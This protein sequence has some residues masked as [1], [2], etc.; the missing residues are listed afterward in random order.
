[1]PN[2]TSQ[3]DSQKQTILCYTDSCRHLE[4]SV[5]PCHLSQAVFQT[6]I[7]IKDKSKQCHNNN[8]NNKRNKTLAICNAIDLAIIKKRECIWFLKRPTQRDKLI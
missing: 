8:N 2:P 5:Y 6:K 4:D 3:L 1:M 7:Q